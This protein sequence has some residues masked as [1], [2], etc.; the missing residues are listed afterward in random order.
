MKRSGIT[1]FLMLTAFEPLLAQVVEVGPSCRPIPQEIYSYGEGMC[2]IQTK[3]NHLSFLINDSQYTEEILNIIN[4]HMVDFGFVELSNNIYWLPD[5]R[6]C[7]FSW[8]GTGTENLVF[9][10]SI[11]LFG[12]LRLSYCNIEPIKYD[13]ASFGAEIQQILEQDGLM[14]SVSMYFS[15]IERDS[16]IYEEILQTGGSPGLMTV[17]D[18]ELITIDMQY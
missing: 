18:G 7:Y 9:I 3:E 8:Y 5:T 14:N 13:S 15:Q 1:L 11:P 4:E 16:K 17:S 10:R 6:S 12:R 2:S